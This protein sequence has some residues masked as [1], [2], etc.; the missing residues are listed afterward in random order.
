MEDFL[1]MTPDNSICEQMITFITQI[2]LTNLPYLSQSYH[3]RHQAMADQ[4]VMGTV[5]GNP[6][7]KCVSVTW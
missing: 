5:A 4:W 7:A 6:V 1:N 2:I 3:N